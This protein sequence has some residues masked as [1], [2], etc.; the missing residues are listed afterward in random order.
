[1]YAGTIVETATGRRALRAPAAPLHARASCSRSRASTRA[2]EEASD[3]DPRAC[4]RTAPTAERAA[5]SAARC[6]LR[7]RQS[8]ARG[9]A[10]PRDRARPLRR[11]ASTRSRRT[12]WHDGRRRLPLA[13]RTGRR[14]ARR[15]SRA[16]RSGFPIRAGLL[17]DRHVGDV[18]AVDD[19]SLR[20]PAGRDARARRRVG[21]RQDDGRPRDPPALRAD[22]RAR[23]LFDGAGPQPPRR[24]GAARRCAGACR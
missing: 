8:R 6:R 1:M 12:E 24:G 22:R 3:A 5:R 18:K 9:S 10:A 17:L 7:G 15:R 4:R 19:V 16:C 23:S 21:L 13:E 20:H 11:A 2:R 14:A